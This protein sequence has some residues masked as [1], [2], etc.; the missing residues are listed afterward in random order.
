MLKRCRVLSGRTRSIQI[1]RKF[2]SIW[3][4][5]FC[6]CSAT[7]MRPDTIG[8]LALEPN[9][10]PAHANL[11]RALVLLDHWQEAV[12][13]FEQALKLG[14]ATV[15][16]Y[17]NM[18][19]AFWH[20]QRF[21]ESLASYDKALSIDPRNP[22]ALNRKGRLLYVLGHLE[23]AR[24]LIEKAI[25]FAPDETENYLNLSEIKRF[26]P[27]DLHLAM[28]EQ[29]LPEIETRPVQDQIELFLPWARPA[30]TSATSNGHL[31]FFSR[32]MRSSEVSS[33]TMNHRSSIILTG[34]PEYSHQI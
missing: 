4:M 19:L 17:M 9:L 23:E 14:S 24:E 5:R 16:L 26:A 12:D 18:G 2:N 8:E 34:L 22:E 15:Q 6:G 11:G 20:L 33:T 29:L 3:Q 13:S 1:W 7:K 32:R 21:Q 10:A 31:I 25:E 27:G 30:V 28:M